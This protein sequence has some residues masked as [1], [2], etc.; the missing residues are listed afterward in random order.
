[1]ITTA[2]AAEEFAKNGF[3]ALLQLLVLPCLPPDLFQE[4]R[5]MMKV[6]LLLPGTSGLAELS[7]CLPAESN[8]DMLTSDQANIYE[9]FV[10]TLLQKWPPHAPSVF[11]GGWELERKREG[12]R[13]LPKGY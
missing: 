11:S 5:H 6:R 13:N 9:V 3:P 10:H 7:F 4:P 12:G 8:S 2:D 1:M